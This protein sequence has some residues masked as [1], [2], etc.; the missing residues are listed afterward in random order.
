MGRDPKVSGAPVCVGGC[1]EDSE[2][3]S[4]DG[5]LHMPSVPCAGRGVIIPARVQ[6]WKEGPKQDSQR[7]ARTDPRLFL[8]NREL[9]WPP[10]MAEPDL[11]CSV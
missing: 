2:D 10:V 11:S 3:R 8:W 4:P 9:T 1:W 5:S 7:L 6:K